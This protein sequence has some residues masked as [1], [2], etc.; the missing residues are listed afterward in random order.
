MAVPGERKRRI[1]APSRSSTVVQVRPSVDD[2]VVCDQSRES[3]APD[4]VARISWGVTTIAQAPPNSRIPVTG[5]RLHPV[6]LG[7]GLRLV[8]GGEGVLPVDSGAA[9]NVGTGAFVAP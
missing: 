7:V 4:P 5:K 3:F 8:G 9:D 2:H 1:P 6:G